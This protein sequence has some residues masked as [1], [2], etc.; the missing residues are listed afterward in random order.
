MEGEDWEAAATREVEEET[1]CKA[2]LGSFV[3]CV[4]YEVKS[5]PKVVLF[6]N[7]YPIGE[8]EFTPSS[9]VDQLVWLTVEEALQRLD[10][11]TEK[12]LLQRSAAS[13]PPGS[14]T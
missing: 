9:E 14:D 5:R 8:C 6:W 12:E 4:S 3:G 13:F 2:R 11:S 7:M 1:G 10:H